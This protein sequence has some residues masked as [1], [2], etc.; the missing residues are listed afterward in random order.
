MEIGPLDMNRVL[1]QITVHLPLHVMP[2]N[3]ATYKV[4][5][6]DRSKDQYADTT[7]NP[8]QSSAYMGGH[9]NHWIGIELPLFYWGISSDKFF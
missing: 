1:F 2:Q 5:K 4:G 8:D 3:I 7:K 9:V 6:H